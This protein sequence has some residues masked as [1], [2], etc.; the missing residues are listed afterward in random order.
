MHSEPCTYFSVSI[1]TYIGQALGQDHVKHLEILVESSIQESSFGSMNEFSCHVGTWLIHDF[2]VPIRRVRTVLRFTSQVFQNIWYFLDWLALSSN[3]VLCQGLPDLLKFKR[4]QSIV[5]WIS[6]CTIVTVLQGARGEGRGEEG[7]A[8]EGVIMEG[9]ASGEWWE[10]MTQVEQD[11]G[12]ISILFISPLTWDA[13][14]P[15][16]QHNVAP[17]TEHMELY[18]G[19]ISSFCLCKLVCGSRWV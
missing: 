3:L 6:Y 12:N 4:T 5:R 2:Q 11:E 13:E 17:C 10:K 14:E 7:L 9:A 16:P 19:D 15:A 8:T 18:C 1:L